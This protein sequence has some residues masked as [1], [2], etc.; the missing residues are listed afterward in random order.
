MIG[1]HAADQAVTHAVSADPTAP[2]GAKTAA[3]PVFSSATV[4]DPKP[5]TMQTL[6]LPHMTAMK[7]DI[8]TLLDEEGC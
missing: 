3:R 2:A 7:A 4:E 5:R 1:S 6:A 8:L